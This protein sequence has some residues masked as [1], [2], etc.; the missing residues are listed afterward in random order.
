MYEQIINYIMAIAPSLTAV[1]G[2]VTMF[3]KTVG[4]TSALTNR[5]KETVEDKMAE[6]MDNTDAQ[7]AALKE[8]VQQVT[9]SNEISI[10]REQYKVLQSELQEALR[11]N[12]ELLAKLDT[13][14]Y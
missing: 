4:N 3:V 9:D 8:A 10:M 5:L 12:A 1:I 11:M 2:A 6:V 14:G 13:R 7:V